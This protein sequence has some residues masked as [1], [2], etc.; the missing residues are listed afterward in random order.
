M[1]KRNWAKCHKIDF[2]ILIE[3]FFNLTNMKL[4]F[5]C[6]TAALLVEGKS[7]VFN[8]TFLQPSSVVFLHQLSIRQT[9]YWACNRHFFTYHKEYSRALKCICWGISILI[10]SK[11][12]KLIRSKNTQICHSPILK[13]LHH[14]D[15]YCSSH[16]FEIQID[17]NYDLFL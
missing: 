5:G 2:S 8:S 9:S 6:K 15:A 7:F 1:T 11:C 4:R 17:T 10:K 12:Q 16:E 13:R 3:S 14:W